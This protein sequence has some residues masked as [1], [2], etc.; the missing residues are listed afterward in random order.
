M[1]Q[2]VTTHLSFHNDLT[3]RE[4][5]EYYRNHNAAVARNLNTKFERENRGQQVVQNIQMRV[6]S[7]TVQSKR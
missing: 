6:R 5:R 3:G 1:F 2:R 4:V 7:K